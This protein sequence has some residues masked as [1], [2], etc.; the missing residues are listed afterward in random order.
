MFRRSVGR[1]FL[2]QVTSSTFIT[3]AT[4]NDWVAVGDFNSDGNLDLA[5]ALRS[6]AG[7]KVLF[8]D[9]AGGFTSGPLTLAASTVQGLQGLA[10]S[11]FNGDGRADLFAGAFSSAS[12]PTVLLGTGTGTF[13]AAGTMLSGYTAF[14]GVATGD[15]NGDGRQDALVTTSNG[16][17]LLSLGN[18]DGSLQNPS[19]AQNPVTGGVTSIV[20]QAPV[21]ADGKNLQQTSP[22][23]FGL[24]FVAVFLGN[25]MFAIDGFREAKALNEAKAR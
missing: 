9:G 11:D 23:A 16:A 3:G 24:M 14:R 13:N 20:E 7:V 5:V 19:Q 22:L 21:F 17:L 6:S 25:T 4:P 12:T 8:G 1:T 18:G 15:F 10:V 2:A